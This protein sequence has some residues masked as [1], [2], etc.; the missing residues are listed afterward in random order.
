M[1]QP[2][3]YMHIQL[4]SKILTV[5]RNSRTKYTEIQA[6]LTNRIT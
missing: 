6:K 3:S 2:I 4:I 1:D 5:Y